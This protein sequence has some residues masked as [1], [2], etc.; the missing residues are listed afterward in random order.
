MYYVYQE[1]N[2]KKVYKTKNDQRNRTQ[3]NEFGNLLSRNDSP[4]DLRKTISLDDDTTDRSYS[5]M[6]LYRK[7]NEADLF[8]LMHLI[9]KKQSGVREV[10]MASLFASFYGNTI[11]TIFYNDLIILKRIADMLER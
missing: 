8:E 2:M 10:E 4:F 7:F 3:S 5:F 1:W 6:G 9:K 11:F